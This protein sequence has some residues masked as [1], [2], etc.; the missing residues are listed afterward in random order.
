MPFLTKE[1]ERVISCLIE[2]KH[3]TPEYYPLTLNSLK[4]ACN[5]KSNREP[6][7]S[8]SEDDIDITDL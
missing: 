2:K 3:T 8:Y 5:Q 4:A 6:V 7:V 1:E